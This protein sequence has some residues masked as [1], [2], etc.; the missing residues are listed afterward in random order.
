M[1]SFFSTSCPALKTA[2]MASV[3]PQVQARRIPTAPRR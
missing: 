2:S 1:Y 3:Q